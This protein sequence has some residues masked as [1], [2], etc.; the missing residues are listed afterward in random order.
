M[1]N[2]S[3]EINYVEFF[4][5]QILIKPQHNFAPKQSQSH[6]IENACLYNEKFCNIHDTFKRV[7][8]ILVN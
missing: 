8:V 6:T 7:I 2:T 3:K 4:L 1:L 5:Y